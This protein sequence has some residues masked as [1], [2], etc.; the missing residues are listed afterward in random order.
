MTSLPPAVSVV[1]PTHNR[2]EL[3]GK[4]L[5]ALAGQT[6]P[7]ERMEVVVVA[8]GCHDGTA[9]MLANYQAPFA[10]KVVEQPG[11]GPS[12]ARNAGVRAAT[13]ELLVFLDDDVLPGSDFLQAHLRAHQRIPGGVVLGPYPPV[14]YA[15]SNLFRLAVRRWWLQHFD[16]LVRPGHRMTYRDVLL[17]NLS[18]TTSLW[19]S[20]DGL[21]PQFEKS[22]E[23]F[24]LGV[25]L[26]KSGAPFQVAA[27]AM[28]LHFEHETMT[29]RGA[30]ARAYEEGR[31]DV[32]LGRK[33][34][35]LRPTLEVVRRRNHARR[36]GRL[37]YALIFGLG[38]T[39]DG[40]M[41]T[42]AR[43]MA[44]CDRYS[45]RNLHGLLHDALRGYWYVRGAANELGS[46]RA[47]SSFAD[48]SKFQDPEPVTIDIALGLP[49][50]EQD[51]DAARPSAAR[52][53]YGRTEIGLLPYEPAAEPWRGSHLRPA[54]SERLAA[55]YL[56]AMARG[57]RVPIAPSSQQ[58]ALAARFNALA[59]FFGPPAP[60]YMWREPDEVWTASRVPSGYR[61][62][63]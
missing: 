1:I 38:G 55:A 12:T 19:H 4:L 50:A 39:L 5:D 54:L 27:D 16:E 45:L 9:E 8:D 52:L 48:L 11:S 24:E 2:R 47:W 10:M 18:L 56:K 36:T 22:R 57:G 41:R 29:L 58:T 34:P 6:C 33:H 43:L 7:P 25:R 28:A 61:E 51:L 17:G 30:M 59:K 42:T 26:L 20:V 40:I 60:G 23:D 35:E 44:W 15:S 21:D 49:A 37:A 3:L 31:S 53:I 63:R 62:T 13:G 46:A 32:R 14:P